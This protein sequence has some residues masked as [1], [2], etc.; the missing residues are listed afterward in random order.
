MAKKRKAAKKTTKKRA[1][2]KRP[3]AGRKRAKRGFKLSTA[4]KRKI[5]A[6]SRKHWRSIT[7]NGTTKS[8]IPLAQ[9]KKNHKRLGETIAKREK[10]AS[11]W[12]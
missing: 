3:A 1:K 6:A 7:G 10:N 4:T 2:S 8:H 11:A 5:G 9:L 12:R